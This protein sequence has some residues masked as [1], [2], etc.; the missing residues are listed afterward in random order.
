MRNSGGSL[1][2]M[3]WSI[4]PVGSGISVELPDGNVVGVED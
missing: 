3:L 1:P 2:M 4:F